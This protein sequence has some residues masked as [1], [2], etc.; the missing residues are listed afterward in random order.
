[1]ALEKLMPGDMCILAKPSPTDFNS[2]RVIKYRYTVVD[3]LPFPKRRGEEILVPCFR[4]IKR[5][6]AACNIDRPDDR[7]RP[8]KIKW[9]ERSKLR[10]LPA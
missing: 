1:M 8:P 7:V 4:P 5:K 10:K 9:I 3:A 6:K 2:C